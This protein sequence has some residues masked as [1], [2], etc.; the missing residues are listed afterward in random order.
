MT[1]TITL[2]SAAADALV[3]A[4]PTPSPLRAVPLEAS[5]AQ[6][7]RS[8]ASTVV[9]TSFVGSVSADTAL[10]LVDMDQLTAAAGTD[11]PLVSINDVLRPALEAAT[12][13]LGAGVLG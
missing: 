11:S 2:H 5:L 10:V 4:L 1:G 7:R 3:T 9:T 8:A 13:V 12:G 6:G